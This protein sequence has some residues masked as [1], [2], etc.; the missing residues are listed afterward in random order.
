[1]TKRKCTYYSFIISIIFGVCVG[2][3]WSY[4]IGVLLLLSAIALA[5][6]QGLRLEVDL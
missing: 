5:L 4:E 6:V 3:F 2:Y 1:M